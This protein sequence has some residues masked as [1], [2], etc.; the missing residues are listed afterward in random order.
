MT[1][2]RKFSQ[3]RNG[4]R[5]IFTHQL[6]FPIVKSVRTL[7]LQAAHVGTWEAGA[8]ESKGCSVQRPEAGSLHLCRTGCYSNGI[9]S[10]P[11]LQ[12]FFFKGPDIKYFK[13]FRLHMVS[14]TYSLL[15]Y[16]PLRHV[17]KTILSWCA[18]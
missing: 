7:H 6:P 1:H 13:L 3:E 12:I 8:A 18:C 9:K 4:A 15:F 16:N 2:K 10:G 5:G 14:V 17:L 11:S